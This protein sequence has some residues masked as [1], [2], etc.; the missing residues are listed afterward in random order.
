MRKITVGIVIA[1]LV[2]IAVSIITEKVSIDNR[3]G[4]LQGEINVIR[5][6]AEQACL[7]ITAA[8][9]QT[10]IPSLRGQSGEEEST[11]ATAAGYH[12]HR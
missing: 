1:L 12:G 6:T 9:H 8:R 5:G 3:L 11:A 4:Q 2:F 10:G 7:P